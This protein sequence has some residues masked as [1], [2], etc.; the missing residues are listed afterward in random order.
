M[1]L[2]SWAVVIGHVSLVLFSTKSA[3]LSFPQSST[4][5]QT[6]AGRGVVLRVQPADKTIVIRHETISNLMPAMTMPFHVKR[7]EE[8][9][10]LA[11]GDQV[12]F[13]LLVSPVESWIDH[14]NKIGATNLPPA[15]TVAT[16]AE[17]SLLDFPF[18]NELGRAVRLNDFHGQALAITFFYTRCPLPD[19][20]PRLSKNFEMAQQTLEAMTNAPTNWHL[21]SVTFEPEVDTPERLQNYGRSYLYDPDHWSFL[22]GS[23]DQIAALARACG[24]EY[25]PDAGTITHNF[26]TLIV[27][28]NG[29][30]QMVFP[31]SGDLSDQIVRELL[32][33][34]TN[35]PPALK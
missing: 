25:A 12:S 33:A 3:A 4:N 23:P 7:P 22:T 19:Y 28:P 24:V 15:T 6:F 26:R 30:L 1:R 8:L 34:A 18:I 13:R 32:K 17:P 2:L 11:A 5:V 9:D 14:L 27:D 29:H 16:N 20:C 10:G 31:T 21:I 35:T